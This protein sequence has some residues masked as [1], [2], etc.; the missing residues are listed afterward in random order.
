MG[1]SEKTN[2]GVDYAFLHGMLAGSVDFFHDKRVNILVDGSTR[3]VPSYFGT[4]PATA[5]L[6]G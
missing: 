5:N 2:I 6:G 1:D 4:T 3:S